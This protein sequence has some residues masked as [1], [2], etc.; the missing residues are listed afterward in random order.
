MVTQL[1]GGYVLTG[2]LHRWLSFMVFF[3][4]CLFAVAVY[5]LWHYIQDVWTVWRYQWSTVRNHWLDGFYAP[6][7]IGITAALL[8]LI[9]GNWTRLQCRHFELLPPDHGSYLKCLAQAP[10]A[11]ASFISNSYSAPISWMTQQWAYF[12]THFKPSNVQLGE[13]GY[14]IQRNTREYLWLKDAPAIQTI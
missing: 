2:Y 14:L 10:F 6:S 11:G 12:D 8:L 3:V 4:N 5:L 13:R 7:L 1:F 9:A